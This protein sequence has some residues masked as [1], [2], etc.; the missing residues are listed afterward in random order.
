MVIFLYPSLIPARLVASRLPL[1]ELGGSSAV[2]T[3]QRSREHRGWRS[4]R[5]AFEN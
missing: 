3:A 2:V 1:D 4:A 5:N